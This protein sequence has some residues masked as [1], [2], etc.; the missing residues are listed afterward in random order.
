[1]HTKSPLRRHIPTN[2]EGGQNYPYQYLSELAHYLWSEVI[3][4]NS[5]VPSQRLCLQDNRFR[6]AMLAFDWLKREVT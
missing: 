1:M 6:H 4:D 5:D 3:L 2:I